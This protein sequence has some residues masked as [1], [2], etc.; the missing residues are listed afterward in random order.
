MPVSVMG[1]YQVPVKQ[2]FKAKFP[3][4]QHEVDFILIFI[5]IEMMTSHGAVM[6]PT[7]ICQKCFYELSRSN[8][9]EN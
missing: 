3:L 5:F 1:K 7:G 8:V 9:I 2:L 6:H 4:N